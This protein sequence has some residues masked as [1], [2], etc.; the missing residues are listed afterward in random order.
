[1]FYFSRNTTG[2]ISSIN[3]SP[4]S[5]WTAPA[6]SRD[7]NSEDGC[8]VAVNSRE[9]WGQ[10]ADAMIW[11]PDL[12]GDGVAEVY[13]ASLSSGTSILCIPVT[14][15]LNSLSGSDGRILL[16]LAARAG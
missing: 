1:M 2:R 11:G 10:P 4:S 13:A 5:F 8:H 12:D 3:R 6:A 9:W 15:Q 7:G 16:E 14:L